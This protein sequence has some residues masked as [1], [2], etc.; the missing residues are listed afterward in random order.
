MAI[1]L[2]N[3]DDRR[4]AD[5][6]E[7]GRALIPLHAPEWTDHNASDPGVTLMELFAWIAE[8]D[9]Y[10]LNRIT[11]RQRRRL[12]RLLGIRPEPPRPAA[13]VCELRA[14]DPASVRLL[15]GTPCEGYGRDDQPIAFRST[16]ALDVVAADLEAVQRGRGTAIADVTAA[17]RRHDPIL[18]FGDDP[19]PG[20]ALLLGFDAP[21]P[22]DAWTTIYILAAGGSGTSAERR[23]LLEDVGGASLPPHHGARVVWEGASAGGPWHPLDADDDTRALTL[24]GAVRLRP[25]AGMAA[26]ALGGISRPLHYVRARFASGAYDEAPAIAGLFVNAL[27]LVQAAA[28]RQTWTIAPG[29]VLTG[30]PVCGQAA[31]VVFELRD[32]AIV[33]LTAT[34]PASGEPA[35]P[36]LGYSPPTSGAAGALTLQAAVVGT[37]AGEPHQTIA[38]GPRPIVEHT[39]RLYS[40]E[41][42]AWRGWTRVDDFAASTRAD[43]HFTLDSTNGALRIGDGEHGRTVPP[44]AL[45]IAAFDAT[46]AEHGGGRVTAVAG[47]G[48]LSV[49]DQAVIEP[50]AAAETLAHAMGRAIASREAPVRAIAAADVEALAMETPGTRIARV[51]VRPNLYPGFDCVR[52]PGVIAVVVVPSLPAARPAPSA[53]LIRAVT[54]RLEPRRTIG[55]RVVVTGP[56]YLEVAAVARIRAFDGVDRARLAGDVA[57]ALDGFLHPLH[58]GPDRTGWPLG[59]DVFR[60]EV[61]QVIDEVAGVDHVLSLELRAGGAAT[62]GNVCLRPTWLPAAG[63]HRIEVL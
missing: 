37:G 2:P 31:H 10:R 23:R 1:P 22:A 30:V 60:A 59:R 38:I 33:A 35:F 57:D 8:G 3:L 47:G 17:W 28:A 50:G 19:Q 25:R 14:P 13:V 48:H 39:F 16:R 45:L 32:G 26:R 55:T 54:R 52:A 36:V 5:L 62:C 34:A 51:A 12:L 24:S 7:Q 6:V 4:W 41:E 11:D 61:M 44:G 29:A 63:A 43:A 40:L 53:G 42:G 56:G 15:A 46:A 18:P 20:A 21:L 58:G 27:E 49:R 9:I